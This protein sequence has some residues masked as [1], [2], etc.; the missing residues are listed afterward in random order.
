MITF[1]EAVKNWTRDHSERNYK[2]LSKAL[3]ALYDEDGQVR[4]PLKKTDDGY[5]HGIFFQDGKG[6]MGI[7]SA[8]DTVR[9]EEGSEIGGMNLVKLVDAMFANP[10]IYGIVFDP[11]TAPVFIDRKNLSLI[12]EKEDPRLERKDWGKGIPKYSDADLMV[13]EEL[14]DFAIEVVLDTIEK[15]YGNYEVYEVY[16][17][18]H[19]VPNIVC[20]EGEQVYFIV[21]E[22]EILPNV[23]VLDDEKKKEALKHAKKF[24]AKLLFAPVSFGSEDEERMKEGLVLSGDDFNYKFD[25][26]VEIE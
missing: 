10:H 13:P 21:V 20:K 2:K 3:K 7:F 15:K 8:D 22:P 18:L 5:L 23:P 4:V 16:N 1:E 26:F 12:I 17:S 9:R 14:L 24:D 25:G 11:Y 6:Y 19:T